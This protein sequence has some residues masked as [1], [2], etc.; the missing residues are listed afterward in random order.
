M[1]DITFFWISF[2][3]YL[4]GFLLFIIYYSLNRKILSKVALWVFGAGLISHTVAIILRWRLSGH[5]PWTNMYEYISVMAWTSVL[6]MII[7]IK[8][9]K[10]PVLGVCLSPISFLLI[11]I[12]SL[13]P[14][15]INNQLVPA[16]QSVW[17]SIHVSLSIIGE[18]AFAVAFGVS[19]MYLIKSKKKSTHKKGS[20]YSRLPSLELLDE[21]N[22]KAISIGYPVFTVGA[23]IAGAIWASKAWGS[24]WSWDPKEVSA[25]II[26][27]FYTIYLH[28]RFQKGW[29]GNKAAV[30][31]IIGFLVTLLSFFGNYI[32]G[33]L[34]SYA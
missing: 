2:W 18:G 1:I 8:K 16:L 9:F 3:L 12:G 21:I 28:A 34:H 25:L 7:I 10:N 23:L 29:K 11:S 5:D 19:I 17:L 14:K 27:I 31:S 6:A 13:L 32:L 4:A 15:D 30:M 26:W 33:G 20:H 24:F 22:Y